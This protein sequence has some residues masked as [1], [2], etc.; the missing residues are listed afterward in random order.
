VKDSSGGIG[1]VGPRNDPSARNLVKAIGLPAS[2]LAKSV[3]AFVN[4]NCLATPFSKGAAL[5]HTLTIEESAERRST[6]YCD[7]LY[8]SLDR[9]PIGQSDRIWSQGTFCVSEQRAGITEPCYKI[10]FLTINM[11]IIQKAVS[12]RLLRFGVSC[13]NR[14]KY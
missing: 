7:S 12:S 2:P 9:L 13:Q 10:S 11:E 8:S 4:L 1:I 3:G 14:S 5:I 6:R